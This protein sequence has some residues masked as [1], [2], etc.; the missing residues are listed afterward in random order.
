M[1][2]QMRYHL[3]LVRMAVIKESTS[4]KCWREH[5]EKGSLLH[6]WWACKFMK[7]LWKTVWRLLSKPKIELPWTYTQTKL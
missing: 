4:Y 3:T 6:C 5:R 1:I 7:P 2:I